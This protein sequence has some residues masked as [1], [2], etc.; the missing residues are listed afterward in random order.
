MS[1]RG[2]SQAK[3]TAGKSPGTLQYVGREVDKSVQVSIT[4]YNA[5]AYHKQKLVSFVRSEAPLTPLR[6]WISFD[7][8]HHGDL[9]ADLGRS[10]RL[11]PLLLEDVMNTLQKPKFEYYGENQLF[12]V[13]KWLE[14]NPYTREV[15][16]EHVAFVLESHVLISFQEEGQRDI[17]EPITQRLEAGVGKTRQS[18]TDYLLY[19]LMDLIADQYIVVADALSENLE[20]L[21]ENLFQHAEHRHLSQLYQ[22]KREISGVRKVVSPIRELV[23][24]LLRSDT[25][26]QQPLISEHT[27]LYLRDLY[28]HL[29]QV[30]DTL[31][32]QRELVAGLM[33]MYNSTVNIRLSNVM[34]VLTIISVIFMPLSFVAGVYGMNFDYI[35]WLHWK[36]G[37]HAVSII[38]LCI[39][40]G[41]LLWFRKKDWL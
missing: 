35:P 9:L 22:I 40:L 28:D 32:N 25:D 36:Y 5:A 18:D 15:E 27:Q 6:T 11:H 33:D 24:G 10:Y 23:S 29:N 7:G 19:A 26:T 37:F 4:T 13:M 8:L 41:M 16:Q 38:M 31:D 17:F 21:E 14:Y 20:K 2:R 34:K 3:A 1:R 30:L 12:V 39:S